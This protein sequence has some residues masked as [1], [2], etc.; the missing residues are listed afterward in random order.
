M[1]SSCGALMNSPEHWWCQNTETLSTLLSFWG[2]CTGGVFSPMRCLKIFFSMAWTSCWT[3]GRFT[4][5]LETS[6]SLCVYMNISNCYPGSFISETNESI[7]IYMYI[8]S[9]IT[10]R[11]RDKWP[12]FSRRHFQMHFLNENVWISNKISLKFVPKGQINNIPTLV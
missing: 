8:Q 6:W 12:P 7:S 10:H 1:T 5:D 3:D 2:E 11:G 9:Y 4:G